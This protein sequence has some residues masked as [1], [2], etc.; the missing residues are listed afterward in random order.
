MPRIKRAVA[1]LLWPTITVASLVIG[2]WAGHRVARSGIL[3]HHTFEP[4]P[5]NSATEISAPPRPRAEPVRTDQLT[6]AAKRLKALSRSSPDLRWDWEALREVDR[7]LAQ[8][9]AS[10]LAS[11]YDQIEISR[12][13]YEETLASKVGGYWAAKDP[14]AAIRAALAKSPGNGE[15]LAIQAFKEWSADQPG[16]ALAW[17]KSAELPDKLDENFRH[18]VLGSLIERDFSLASSAYLQVKGEEVG[19]IIQSWGRAYSDDPEMRDKLIDFSK[20]TGRPEDYANLN[21]GLMS[22][23]PQDDALGMLNYIRGLKDYLE[24]N[25]VPAEARPVTDA[26]AVTAA[27]EREYTGPALE[28]WMERYAESPTT[29]ASLQGAVKRWTYKA[30]DAAIQWLAQQPESLQRDSLNASVTSPLVNTGH[31]AEA[32]QSIANIRDPGIQQQAIESLDYI[33]TRKDPE[34]AAAWRA[35][36]SAATPAK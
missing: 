32:A 26:A 16:A 18:H 11:L 25:A 14:D 22:S 7:I 33:W 29:P 10:E 34:S 27:M 9:S 6:T 4:Q 36:L 17:L 12:G 19:K 5:E 2:N 13:Y 1:R 21:T 3:G 35:T 24:S 30:P 23:W 20:G 28:W 8:L 31:Y 15:L